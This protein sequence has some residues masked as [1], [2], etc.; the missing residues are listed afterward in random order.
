LPVANKKENCYIVYPSNSFPFGPAGQ[1]I[2]LPGEVSGWKNLTRGGKPSCNF[3]HV[4]FHQ[5]QLFITYTD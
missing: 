2:V 1:F 5:K 4:N 3:F